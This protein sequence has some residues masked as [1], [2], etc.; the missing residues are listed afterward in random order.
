MWKGLVMIED[1]LYG[2]GEIFA[3]PEMHPRYNDKFLNGFS[4]FAANKVR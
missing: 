2:L 4:C 1:I 3:P